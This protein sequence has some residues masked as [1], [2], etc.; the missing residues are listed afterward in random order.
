MPLGFDI[1]NNKLIQEEKVLCANKK[2]KNRHFLYYSQLFMFFGVLLYC[3]DWLYIVQIV[4][5]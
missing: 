5:D 2:V 3:I 1:F 4:F